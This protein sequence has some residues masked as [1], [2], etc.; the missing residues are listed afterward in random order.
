MVTN[1]PFLI[2]PTIALSPGLPARLGC[3]RTLAGGFGSLILAIVVSQRSTRRKLSVAAVE[4][5][6]P[7]FASVELAEEVEESA[8][9]EASSDAG[10][11][12]RSD[13]D[14][15]ESFEEACGGLDSIAT[16]SVFWICP[17]IDL[18]SIDGDG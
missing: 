2:V 17:V 12:V 1:V 15:V 14:D 4:P 11:S 5:V 8:V 3:D 10:A 9:V 18:E 7:P 16:D 13:D 6:E